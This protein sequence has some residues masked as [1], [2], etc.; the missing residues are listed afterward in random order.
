MCLRVPR[1]NLSLPLVRRYVIAGFPSPADNYVDTGIDLNEELIHHPSST[2]FL[3]VRGESMRDAGILDGDLLIVDRSLN[4]QPGDIVVAIIDGSFIVKRLTYRK[5]V[6]YL[7]AEHP[8]YP[9]IDLSHYENVQIWG[10]ATFSVHKLN[11]TKQEWSQIYGY[12]S[13]R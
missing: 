11:L 1:S 2:F 9:A 7:E 10:V 4:P 12:R 13:S 6:S 5:N 8:N 3:R